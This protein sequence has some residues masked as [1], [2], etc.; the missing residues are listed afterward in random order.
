MKRKFSSLLASAGVAAFLLGSV[1]ALAQVAPVLGTAAPYAVLGRNAIPIPGTVTCTGP[2]TI[3]GQVGTTFALGITN[4]PA[5][6]ITG[7]IVSPVPAGV[8]ADF[9]AAFAAI[10]AL[11]PV[12]SGGVIP[13]ASAVIAPGVYCTPAGHT[14]VGPGITYTLNGT[15]SDVWVFRVGTGGPGALSLTNVNVVMGGTAQPCNVYWKTSAAATITDTNFVGTILS[16]T[17]VTM[18]RGSWTGRGMATTDITLT[19]PAPMT[20]AGCAA[21]AGAGGNIPTLSEWAMIV[22][23]GLLALFGFVAVRRRARVSLN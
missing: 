6:A 15:A 13:P 10:D 9:D 23:G 8:T 2:G 3:N 17:A 12:C 1:P 14:L 21:P 19:D 4:V 16:G 22:L 5:C 18:T 20:F 11:N 7:P